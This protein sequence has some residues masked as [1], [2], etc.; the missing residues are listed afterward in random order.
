M[1]KKDKTF[2]NLLERFHALKDKEAILVA[3]LEEVRQKINDEKRKNENI[4]LNS[5]VGKYFKQNLG[6]NSYDIKY[7][8]FSELCMQTGKI[9][10]VTIKSESDFSHILTYENESA[11]HFLNLQTD[12][13]EIT[14]KEFDK[15]YNRFISEVEKNRLVSKRNVITEKY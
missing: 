9:K 12:F 7:R 6:P 4:F 11:H 8:F 15:V 10:G 14:K 2:Q 5:F 3:E 13:V 1:T